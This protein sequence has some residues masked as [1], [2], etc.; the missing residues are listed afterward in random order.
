[1]EDSTNLFATTAKFVPGALRWIA[2]ELFVTDPRG[3]MPRATVTKQTDIYALGMVY[4]VRTTAEALLHVSHESVNPQEIYTGYAPFQQK[5]PVDMCVLLPVMRGEIPDRP[6]ENVEITD[7]I[8]EIWTSCWDRD[9][10]RRPTAVQIA[11]RLSR[12]A[13]NT[14]SRS[15]AKKSQ[16]GV[17]KGSC[18]ISLR[19]QRY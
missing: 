11:K 1:L 13:D 3:E 14:R 10:G 2:P 4:L 6:S 15:K 8:W 7:E 19:S 5:Y 17:P 12:I 9:T 18:A 16:P